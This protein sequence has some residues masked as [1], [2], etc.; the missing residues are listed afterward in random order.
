[1]VSAYYLHGMHD[2]ERNAAVISLPS[3]STIWQR[4]HHSPFARFSLFFALMQFSVAIASPFFTV[5]MLRDLNYSYL[6]FMANTATSVL[7]QFLTLNMWGRISDQFGNRIILA[8]TGLV[9]PVLPTLWLFS[10]DFVYLLFVQALAGLVWA[11]FSL[12][13]GNFIYDLV[14]SPKRATYVAYHNVLMS[15]CVFLGAVLGGYLGWVLPQQL[16]I[17]EMHLEWHSVLLGVFVVSSLAR[18]IIALVFIPMLREVREVQPLSVS[19]LVF[20]VARF[21][22]LAGLVFD[23]ILPNRR[24]AGIDSTNDPVAKKSSSE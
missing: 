17:G 13:A 12:S 20:R 22:A 15:T 5:Y 24:R 9:I 21:N 3:L 1:M 19:G 18:L 6:M 23:V 16:V 7:V 10:P 4:I 2:P 11:G 8:T 14:P